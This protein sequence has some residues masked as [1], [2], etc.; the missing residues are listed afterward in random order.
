MLS[1]KSWVP[2][3]L[4]S[5][6]TSPSAFGSLKYL[7]SCISTICIL[8]PSLSIRLLLLI[9]Q[10]EA[11]SESGIELFMLL[12][13]SEVE[14]SQHSC[15]LPAPPDVSQTLPCVRGNMSWV[16]TSCPAL[17]GQETSALCRRRVLRSGVPCPSPGADGF[18]FHSSSKGS[19]CVPRPRRG[20]ENRKAFCS[21]PSGLRTFLCMK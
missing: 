14:I 9:S 11:H 6:L 8:S 19:G 15:I 20:G 1:W 4:F 12:G 21:S 10:S 13:Y 17:K 18:Y 2:E 7:V 5:I 3:G 16:G